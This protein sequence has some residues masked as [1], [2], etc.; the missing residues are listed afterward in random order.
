MKKKLYICSAIKN[1]NYKFIIKQGYCPFTKE[2]CIHSVP[3][4]HIY[5]CKDS[6]FFTES[7]SLESSNSSSSES[8]RINKCIPFIEWD[9]LL[10][11][12]NEEEEFIKEEEFKI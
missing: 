11:I 12:W 1:N 8:R 4:E 3:H 2:E 9:N 10:I 5:F 7:S 6:C